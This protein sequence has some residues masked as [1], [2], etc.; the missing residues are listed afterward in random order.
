MTK[1]CGG[2]ERL[3]AVSTEPGGKQSGCPPA[4]TPLERVERILGKMF[5]RGQELPGGKSQSHSST[6][7]PV[8]SVWMGTGEGT[9]DQAPLMPAGIKGG[10]QQRVFWGHSWPSLAVRFK[11]QETKSTDGAPGDRVGQEKRLLSV[12]RAP[13]SSAS[14]QLISSD[15]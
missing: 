3:Q 15:L 13:G 1:R 9:R 11:E 7:V 6:A 10:H 12:S 14:L 2:K 4:N 5:F 8:H